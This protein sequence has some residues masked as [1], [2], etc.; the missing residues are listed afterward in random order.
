[1][2]TSDKTGEPA[3]DNRPSSTPVLAPVLARRWR[4]GGIKPSPTFATSVPANDNV[5]KTATARALRRQHGMT[6][7]PARITQSEINRVVRAAKKAGATEI[8]VK[9]DSH[10]PWVKIV[11]PSANHVAESEDIVV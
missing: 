8:E 3:N 9:L 2:P 1:M 11:L 5:G 7:R 4:I 6:N 10:G